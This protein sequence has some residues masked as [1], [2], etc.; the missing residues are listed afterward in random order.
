MRYYPKD[1]GMREIAATT[2]PDFFEIYLDNFING[3]PMPF[4][5]EEE[6]HH[7]RVAIRAKDAAV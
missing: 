2:P 5:T 1:E 6:L 7:L 4:T 3:T